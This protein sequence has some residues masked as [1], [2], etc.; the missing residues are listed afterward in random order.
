MKRI[1][2]LT[3]SILLAGSL[4]RADSLVTFNGCT[5][6]GNS[7]PCSLKI[8][9]DPVV[10]AYDDTWIKL[11][12]V[13]KGQSWMAETL[14]LSTQWTEG[15]WMG[16][17]SGSDYAEAAW[18]ISQEPAGG[19]SD[20]QLAIFNLFTP[21]V[22]HSKYWTAGA[23][24]WFNKAEA[25]NFT[26]N[27]FPG[28]QIIFPMEGHNPAFCRR[29]AWNPCPPEFILPPTASTPP[30][31]TPEPASILLLGSGLLGLGIFARR[32]VRV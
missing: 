18:L 13:T 4:A 27:M 30:P 21:W 23:Q 2:T 7:S 12:P 8:G 11:S 9:S 3:V 6:P 24:S 19:S 28:F 26:P 1:I 32:K 14:S 31:S 10:T 15:M 16:R 25:G 29:D 22:Q 17:E 5:G 20:I